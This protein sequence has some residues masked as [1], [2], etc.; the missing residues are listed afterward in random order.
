MMNANT[1]F[2]SLQPQEH[3]AVDCQLTEPIIPTLT[4]NLG[5]TFTGTPEQLAEMQA[6]LEQ[7]QLNR[8]GIFALEFQQMAQSN[9]LAVNMQ[10]N[11][12][13]TYDLAG[14]SADRHFGSQIPIGSNAIVDADYSEE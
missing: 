6:Q 12:H 10:F 3:P 7:Q 4:F 14:D 2:G 9:G 1:Q 8:A 11:I 13:N 5:S